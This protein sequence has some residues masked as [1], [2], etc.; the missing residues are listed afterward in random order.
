[1]RR[2]NMGQLLDEVAETMQMQASRKSLDF[3]L[4]HPFTEAFFCTGDPFRLKQILYNLLGNAIKFTE[5]GSVT[6]L[7]E[8]DMQSPTK[9]TFTVKDTGIGIAEAD[10]GRIFNQF[11]QAELSQSVLPMVPGSD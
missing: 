10:L 6:L 8:A 5:Q 3:T 11:E 2:F 7:V 9:V 4:K 1:M